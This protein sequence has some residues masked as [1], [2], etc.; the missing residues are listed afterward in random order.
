MPPIT[1]PRLLFYS[2]DTFGL[3]HIRRTISISDALVEAIPGATALVLTGASSF[4]TMQARAAVD[5]VKL[6]SV[7]KIGDEQY[8]SKFL[9]VRFEAVRAMREQIILSTARAY[10]PDVLI[11]DNVPLGMAGELGS[12]LLALSHQRP[13]PRVIL[14]LRDV[15]DTPERVVA[16]WKNQGTHAAL[17]RLYDDVI[18]YGMPEVF[19]VVKEYKLPPRIAAKVTYAGY[20]ERAAD[21]GLA[22]EIRRRHVSA[23]ERLVLVTVGGGGDGAALIS[24]YLE[25]LDLRAAT[26]VHSLVVLGPDL[27]EPE[28]VRL[29]RQYGSRADVTLVDYCD[30]MPASMA[31]ADVVVAMGGYNTVCEILALKKRAVIV[32]RVV[33]RLEQWVRC[34]RLSE[35]GLIN[36]L[37]PA[38]ATPVS[39]WAEIDRA[40]AGPRVPNLSVRFDGLSV[41]SNLVRAG[42]ATCLAM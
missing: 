33:P 23:G 34:Q 40:L 35:L 39:L 10:Q 21:A 24:N 29:H 25:G 26:G 32:P 8:A 20:I 12:T 4:R 9:D 5:F 19:D 38:A 17:E 6:P 11:V 7:T 14:T 22:A 28:R 36:V 42:H 2:H 41:V 16:A 15:L 37:H 30:Q 3:G 18:V 27:P 13:R 31:A 1:A